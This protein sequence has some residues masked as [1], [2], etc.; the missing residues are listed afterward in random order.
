MF[1]FTK[2]F[3]EEGHEAIKVFQL[4]VEHNKMT[5]LSLLSM[6]DGRAVKDT[7]HQV[8]SDYI[9]APKQRCSRNL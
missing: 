5:P 3:E 4:A 1:D 2:M 9:A 8:T 7:K 6:K